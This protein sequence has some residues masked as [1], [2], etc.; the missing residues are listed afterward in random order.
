MWRKYLVF[1]WMAG[2]SLVEIPAWGGGWE[3]ILTN[4]AV[5]FTKYH[6]DFSQEFSIPAEWE[7]YS[8]QGL[9]KGVFE[10]WD[11]SHVEV[12]KIPASVSWIEEGA[13]G[14]LIGLKKIEVDPANPAYCDEEG[15][16][17]DKNKTVLLRYPPQKE[18]VTIYQ[19][20]TG[21]QRIGKMAFYECQKLIS[22]RVPGSV[23]E[24]G[25]QA[26]AEC[27]HLQ[28]VVF[29][30]GIQQIG[31]QAFEGCDTLVI[32]TLPRSVKT[33]GARAFSGCRKLR[34][35]KFLGQIEAIG[36]EAF[37]NAGI[38]SVTIPGS[39]E[40]VGDG[41]FAGCRRLM[42][43]TLEEG[44]RA[45]G[46]RAFEGCSSLTSVRIPASVEEIGE[47]AWCGCDQLQAIEVADGNPWYWSEGGVLFK[48]GEDVQS[49]ILIQYPAGKEISYY[50]IPKNVKRIEARA[51]EGC[52]ALVFVKIPGSVE[53]IGER[54]FAWCG[55]LQKVILEEGVR[56][57]GP[58]AFEWCWGLQSVT[59][60]GSVQKIGAGAFAYCDKLRSVA[61]REG[62]QQIGVEAFE[63]CD[64]LEEVVLPG[65]VQEIEAKAFARCGRL[66][67]VV[68]Q[69]GIQR[70]GAEAFEGCDALASVTIPASVEEI[71]EGAW[72]GCDQLEAI[73]VAD[74]NPRYW[75]K[76][77]VLLG[78]EGVTPMEVLLQYPAGKSQ[79]TYLIPEG[80]NRIGEKAFEHSW[81][82]TS[83]IFPDSVHEIAWGSLLGTRIQNLYFLG[84]APQVKGGWFGKDQALV[85]YLPGTEGW[86]EKFGGCRTIEWLPEIRTKGWTGR[87]FSLSVAWAPNRNVVL[88]GTADLVHGPWQTLGTLRLDRNGNAEFVDPES[89]N[90]PFFFYRVRE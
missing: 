54:A 46:A 16:L 61:L 51:M 56:T 64:F 21:I 13:L 62:I 40:R 49:A 18:D 89:Q 8:V 53:E 22:I 60:P 76:D 66:Q 85:W 69:E 44:I 77:G 74:G 3:F 37:E 72:A 70:I 55:R 52:N 57:I 32:I 38:V 10:R 84:D 88:E 59:I 34:G 17:W 80:V 78:K 33:I 68:L 45:I 28:S 87:G 42:T 47:G 4:H 63:G 41:A 43:L 79:E 35:V 19:I 1:G 82:L 90:R 75:S 48:K 6:G 67:R 20:P 14:P 24:I 30:E 65:S 12:L 15:I 26:F 71:G 81:A 86:Q 39:V 5:I 73:Q 2:F 50:T 9:Q 23:V 29:A 58:R 7:G 11:A 27:D 83:V 31:A 25:P 36:P